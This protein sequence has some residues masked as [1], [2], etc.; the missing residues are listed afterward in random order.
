MLDIFPVTPEQF[1]SLCETHFRL[2]K[3]VIAGEWSLIQIL[4]LAELGQNQ[5]FEFF[6]PLETHKSF[7]STTYESGDLWVEINLPRASECQGEFHFGVFG[8]QQN[9][10]KFAIC[11][12]TQHLL[13]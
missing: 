5:V 7:Y 12:I 4:K 2:C 9:N 1:L 3:R 10:P 6:F 8:W 11:I 13:W